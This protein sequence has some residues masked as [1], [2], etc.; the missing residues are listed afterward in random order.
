MFHH[1]LLEL[2]LLILGAREL[3]A[4]ALEGVQLRLLRM[5]QLAFILRAQA[6]ELLREDTLR[7]QHI[8]LALLLGHPFCLLVRGHHVLVP[9]LEALGQLG[10]TEM[11]TSDAQLR[12]HPILR[13]TD[14]RP[15]RK[16]QCDAL[17]HKA[18]RKF[19]MEL[20]DALFLADCKLQSS[21]LLG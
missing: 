8:V 4:Q 9:V 3:H 20:V 16:C 2:L 21:L 18:P 7:R 6:L 15:R 14:A 1:F 17:M 10:R 12:H 5:L 13:G 11:I 19:G